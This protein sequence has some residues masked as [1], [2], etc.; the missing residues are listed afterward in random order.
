MK[1]LEG[2]CNL[3]DLSRRYSCQVFPLRTALKRRASRGPWAGRSHPS[4]TR[5]EAG[6]AQSRSSQNARAGPRSPWKE[7]GREERFLSVTRMSRAASPPVRPEGRQGK[8]RQRA[9]ERERKK[10]SV[11]AV[12]RPASNVLAS[13]YC[14]FGCLLARSVARVVVRP[15]SERKGLAGRFPSSKRKRA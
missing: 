5:P 2:R 13:Q 15:F 4:S 10:P 1:A 14:L 11:V 9:E 7:K 3:T 12:M 8:E 6:E